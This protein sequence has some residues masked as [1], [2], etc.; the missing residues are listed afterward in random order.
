MEYRLLADGKLAA[1]GATVQAFVSRGKGAPLPEEL[2]Q[3]IRAVEARV[4]RHL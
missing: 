2:K 1:D 3:R 4:G